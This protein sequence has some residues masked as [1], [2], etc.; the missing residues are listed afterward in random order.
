MFTVNG[1]YCPIQLSM[2]M[3]RL[4]FI[5][6]LLSGIAMAQTLP[7][8][9]E[10]GAD[11]P[12]SDQAPEV[13]WASKVIGVSSQYPGF[14]VLGQYSAFQV[15]GKPNKLPA[16]GSS[17]CAWSPLKEDSRYEEYITVGYTQ[18]LAIRQVAIGESFNP[19]SISR[20]YVYDEA[21]NEYQIYHNLNTGPVT[22]MGRMLHVLTEL[23]AYKVVSVKLIL[24]TFDVPGWNHIDAIGISASAT[25]VRAT[26]NLPEANSDI[27]QLAKAEIENLGPG[28]NS[29]Y[30]EIVPVISPDGQTLYFDRKNHP[31]NIK[32]DEETHNDDI[33]VS[34]LGPD[35]KWGQAKRLKEPLNNKSHNFVCTV[36]PDGNTIL[37]ANKY[38]PEGKSVGGISISQRLGDNEWSF[39]EEVKILNYHNLN[40]YSEFFLANNQQVLLFAIERNDTYGSRDLYV[41]FKQGDG[42]WSEPKNFG[43]TINTASTEMTPFLAAD[44]RTLYFASSG[45]SGY[46]E[47]DMFVSRRLDDTWTKWSE[48]VNLGPT[49]NSRDWDASYTLDA[50]GEYAY[51]VSYNNAM[52]RSADIFRAA[53]PN[54]LRPEAVVLLTGKVYN[55]KTGEPITAQIFYETLPKGKSAG[56]A[57]TN[58]VTGEYKIVLPYQSAYGILAKAPGFL[59]VNE[60]IDL[61]EKGTYQE[62]K[63]DLYLAPIEV[64]QSIRLNNVFFEQGTANLQD[65]S[66][67][68]LNRIVELMKENAQM[69]I[70]L[71]GHTDIEGPPSLN[72]KLAED[73]VRIIKKY[74]TGQGIASGRVATTAFGPKN[75]ISRKRDEASKRLNRRVEFKVLKF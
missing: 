74:L 59:S 37:L 75:P 31:E 27:G 66:F 50:K 10:A 69:K 3:L 5:N 12:T 18:P 17:A 29:Q 48:P 42:T 45:F 21:G 33:W 72:M 58:P 8:A 2:N 35:G 51:F 54:A 23:T 19:G 1:P 9:K 15:L 47:T 63:K 43:P 24:S 44:N 25:P 61:N 49:F 53:L 6:L 34:Q 36:T 32:S 22:E 26:I 38:V 70:E 56:N 30:E 13:Q 64:G 41:S 60:H 62:V 20:V 65:E 67:P 52:G 73:R 40:K 11:Q 68:E 55:A 14:G 28:V 16:T 46:G 71:E 57:S 7:R 4:F 39:P